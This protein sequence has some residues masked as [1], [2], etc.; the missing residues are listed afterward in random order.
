MGKDALLSIQKNSSVGRGE[1]LEREDGGE[2][3]RG[4][5]G[6]CLLVQRAHGRLPRRRLAGR[7]Q[8][9]AGRGKSK[10]YLQ[11]EAALGKGQRADDG[12]FIAEMM[13]R[14]GVD[15]AAL[16]QHSMAAS[17]F[18]APQR[19]AIIASHRIASRG[20]ANMAVLCHAGS[21]RVCKCIG[22]L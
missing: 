11:I 19:A 6:G 12:L 3:R 2:E 4:W 7:S 21:S 1:E 8:S 10:L 15:C 20:R 18:T 17:S 22:V 14:R 5:R 13:A 16:A 9:R